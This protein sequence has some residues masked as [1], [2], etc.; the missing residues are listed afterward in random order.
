MQ[1]GI[2]CL[3]RK[4]IDNG[5]TTNRIM[6]YGKSASVIREVGRPITFND[7]EKE[8]LEKSGEERWKEILKIFSIYYVKAGF[9]TRKEGIWHLTPEGLNSLYLGEVNLYKIAIA[10]YRRWNDAKSVKDSR[11]EHA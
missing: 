6:S 3:A 4:E 10:A 11:P 7:W 2:D 9:L 8:T 1:T 5:R